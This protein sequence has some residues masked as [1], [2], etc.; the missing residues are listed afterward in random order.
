MTVEANDVMQAIATSRLIGVVRCGGC[1]EAVERGRRLLEIGVTVVEVALTTPGAFE[2]I[3]HLVALAQGIVGVGTCI[4]EA[5]TRRAVAVGAQ[6]AI[7]PTSA[8]GMIAVARESGIVAIPAAFTPSEAL[9]A[10][11]RGADAVKL[12]P[13]SVYGPSG[14]RDLREALPQIPLIPTGGVTMAN[15]REWLDAGAT[16]VGMGGALSRTTDAELRSLV[17]GLRTHEP[18]GG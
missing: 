18:V 13:A 9:D 8:P 11:E 6:F 17:A 5:S 10:I 3:E 7:A 4:D 2:A 12:F 15:A 16:A 14:L 1:D